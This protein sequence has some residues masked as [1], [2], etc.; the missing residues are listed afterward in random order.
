MSSSNFDSEKIIRILRLLG[1]VS[2]SLG[3]SEGMTYCA[4]TYTET[5]MVDSEPST[6][7]HFHEFLTSAT[8]SARNNPKNSTIGGAIGGVF[9]L[10]D[11]SSH[12][13]GLGGMGDIIWLEKRRNETP[14]KPIERR[15]NQIYRSLY[16][17]PACNPKAPVLLAVSKDAMDSAIQLFGRNDASGMTETLSVMEELLEKRKLRRAYCENG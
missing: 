7:R 1:A 10:A 16:K 11:T 13:D 15:A 6:Q 12:S 5:G 2:T 14:Y 8:E 4:A 3:I 9:L 17:D